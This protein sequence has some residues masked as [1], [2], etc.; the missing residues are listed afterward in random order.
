[1]K[2]RPGSARITFRILQFGISTCIV[3]ANAVLAHSPRI[4]FWRA[5]VA[6]TTLSRAP[7]SARPGSGRGQR[8]CAV[9][10]LRQCRYPLGLTFWATDFSPA[11]QTLAADEVEDVLGKES[12]GSSSRA[13]G[14]RQ[15]C[16]TPD[17]P[18]IA[19]AEGDHAVNVGLRGQRKPSCRYARELPSGLPAMSP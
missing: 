9:R 12:Q 19:R 6:S 18:R 1:M 16:R 17:C 2:T 3:L 5:S 10:D 4:A 11:T 13:S 14:R 8:P 7:S 15:P